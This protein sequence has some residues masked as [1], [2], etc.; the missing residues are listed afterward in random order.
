MLWASVNAACKKEEK[1]T[2]R[3]RFFKFYL[4]LKMIGEK[5]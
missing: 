2:R 1:E 3:E 4:P 5:L